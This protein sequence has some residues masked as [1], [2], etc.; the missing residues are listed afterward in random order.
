[1]YHSQKAPS[2]FGQGCARSDIFTSSFNQIMYQDNSLMAASRHRQRLLEGHRLKQVRREREI[3][4]LESIQ[5]RRM[6]ADSYLKHHGITSTEKD[7]EM[8]SEK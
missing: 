3:Q 5:T 8:Y 1:M 7:V 2:I 6:L 4:K